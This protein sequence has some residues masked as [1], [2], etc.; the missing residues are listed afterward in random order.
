MNDKHE[1]GGME[2][3]KLKQLTSQAIGSFKDGALDAALYFASE[4]LSSAA[5]PEQMTEFNR[6]IAEIYLKK[7]NPD[8]ALEYALNGLSAAQ[9]SDSRASACAIATC[10]GKVYVRLGKYDQADDMWEYALSLANKMHD[11][12]KAGRI[13]LDLG[14]NDHR[15]GE[16]KRARGT[17][18]LAYQMLE[19]ASDSRGMVTCLGRLAALCMEEDDLESARK[20]IN[21]LQAVAA[22]RE[23]DDLD[24]LVAFRRGT[25]Y[26]KERDYSAAVDT[27]DV[28]V[29]SFLK[30][31]DVKNQAMAGCELCRAHVRL[32]HAEEVNIVL[33]IIA[34]LVDSPILDHDV[35]LVMA[36]IAAW[37]ADRDAALK[38]YR[39]ALKLAEGIGN[40]DRFRAFHE[41][42]CDTIK[43]GRLP[44][45]D[46][47]P[48]LEK[49]CVECKR[50]GLEKEVE[51]IRKLLS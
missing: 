36:E 4:G 34:S 43:E 5:T 29:K 33:D 32:G 19:R 11:D 14:I 9:T 35:R 13:M 6:I 8:K 37:Q 40:A 10:L 51:E 30:M 17:I 22:E 48:L 41:S 18:E 20:I 1:E 27:F 16:Y 31:G 24:A 38:H 46:T 23:D 26:M 45:A 49:A 12:R 28:A 44:L 7:N 50:M 25:L 47:R 3:G 2:K 42:I 15:R 39:E 21:Q